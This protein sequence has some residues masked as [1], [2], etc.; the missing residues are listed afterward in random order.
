MQSPNSKAGSYEAK[1]KDAVIK[2]VADAAG[3]MPDGW[4]WSEK[5]AEADMAILREDLAVLNRSS[6]FKEMCRRMDQS[7]SRKA[8]RLFCPWLPGN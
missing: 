7:E 1:R 6:G 4:D 5:V 8:A 3:A 2:A